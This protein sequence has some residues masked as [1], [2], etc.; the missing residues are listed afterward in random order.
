MDGDARGDDA[1]LCLFYVISL[2]YISLIAN[3]VGVYCDG[4]LALL[5]TIDVISTLDTE[6][7]IH[8]M[9]IIYENYLNISADLS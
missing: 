7:Y 4:W 1:C 3:W 8:I 9:E 5:V 6:I 2:I